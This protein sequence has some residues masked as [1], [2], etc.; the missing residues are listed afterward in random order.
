MEL[1]VRFCEDLLP[2]PPFEVWR[3]DFQANRSTHLQSEAPS[4]RGPRADGPV[5]TA[6]RSFG[7]FGDTW[8]AALDVCP[9]QDG[10]TGHLTYHAESHPS[11]SLRTAD[12]FREPDAEAVRRRFLEFDDGT[13][14]AFLR[15]VLP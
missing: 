10:W 7:A 5:T 3:A 4:H 2:L 9:G 14:Q 1:L 8:Y 11:R 12:L 13:L 6:F 15:S